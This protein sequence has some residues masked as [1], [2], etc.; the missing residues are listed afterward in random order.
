LP[1]PANYRGAVQEITP[2]PASAGEP[3]GTLLALGLGTLG[4]ALL[5]GGVAAWRW[6][7]D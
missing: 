7:N 4:G 1:A 2:T 5:L 6:R 3:S